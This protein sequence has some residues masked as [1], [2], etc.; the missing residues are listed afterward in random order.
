MGNLLERVPE[1]PQEEVARVGWVG[2]RFVEGVGRMSGWKDAEPLVH[3]KAAP[4]GG[5]HR[6]YV[7]QAQ[8]GMGGARKRDEWGLCDPRVCVAI[9]SGVMKIIGN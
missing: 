9:F 1:M 6:L 7:R 2:P 3:T 5:V 8:D 4:G